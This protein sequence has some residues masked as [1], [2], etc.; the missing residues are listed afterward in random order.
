MQHWSACQEPAPADWPAFFCIQQFIANCD[1]VFTVKI[2]RRCD[3]VF[4]V[5]IGRRFMDRS[6]WWQVWHREKMRKNKH[7]IYCELLWYHVIICDFMWYD[8]MIGDWWWWFLITDVPLDYPSGFIAE[9]C[10]IL[11]MLVDHGRSICMLICIGSSSIS[12]AA[13]AQISEWNEQGFQH[14]RAFVRKAAMFL[15]L[16]GI[17]PNPREVHCPKDIAV[18]WMEHGDDWWCIWYISVL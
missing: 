12:P 18:I 2:C 15:F 3:S 8:V 1:S 16:K 10:R 4:T 7:V 6:G 14:G 5:K 9:I 11:Q 17:H 13:K